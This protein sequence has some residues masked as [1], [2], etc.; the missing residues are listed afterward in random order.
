MAPM[1]RIRHKVEHTRNKHSR[2]VC[3]GDTI[4]I[5]LAKNLSRTE[6]QE[7]IQNLLRR[8]TQMVLEERQKTNIDP[9]RHLLN[10]GQTLTVRLSTG[11]RITFSLVPST[12]T[13]ATRTTRGWTISVSP[14]LRRRALHRLLWN[15]LAQEEKTR[16]TNLVHQ[17]NDEL[18]GVRIR[19]VK[20][21]FATTQWGS[22]SS[23]GVIMLNAALFF[24]EPSILKYV[25]VH[26]LAHRIHSN[27]SPRYWN[28]VEKVM[29]TYERPYKALQNYRLPTL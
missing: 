16:I 15:A 13:K 25:I 29:P 6:E 3:K 5:R 28:E 23:R 18:F 4:I 1:R 20:L 24:T 11:K 14:Q 9:F 27:H 12:V 22:C 2:A 7:H 19:E 17:L 10:G 26:E 8:M 21:G